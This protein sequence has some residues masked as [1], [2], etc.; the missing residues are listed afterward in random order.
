[1]TRRSLLGGAAAAIAASAQDAGSDE[2]RQFFLRLL[3]SSNES[4]GRMLDASQPSPRPFPGRGVGRG[5]NVAA[6][7]AAYCA[8]ESSYY[9]SGNLIP[10]METAS[11]AFVAAQHPDG[12]LDAGNLL[13]HRIQHSLWRRWLH[14]LQ[15]CGG[16]IIRVSP[17]S[18]RLLVSSFWPLARRWLQEESIL[19]TIGG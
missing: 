17:E 1:M 10:V 18:R 7:T 8:P 3:R 16:W 12:T 13:S 15:C 19:R 2:G 11:A 4:V 6:L 14:H 5:A 9:K